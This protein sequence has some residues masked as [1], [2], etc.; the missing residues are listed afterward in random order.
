MLLRHAV[1]VEPPGGGEVFSPCGAPLPRGRVNK[2]MPP[3]SASIALPPLAPPVMAREVGTLPQ[4]ED[5]I[6]EFLWGGE[7]VRGVKQ[8]DSVHLLSRDGRDLTNRF[9]RIAAAIAKLRAS[10]AIIDGEIVH[11][12]MYPPAATRVLIQASDDLAQGTAALLAYDL[13]CD[14]GNDI[15]RFSLLCR[16]LLLAS[17]VQATPIALSPVIDLPADRV[18]SVAAEHGFHGVVAKRAGAPYRPNSS[19][20]DWVKV[21]FASGR[22]ARSARRKREEALSWS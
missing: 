17:A 6:Y 21:T 20:P 22:P 11:L 3:V 14:E 18:L 13:L 19:T 8:E 16:R 9:P 1:R 12:T 10:V 5:W 15:R 4:G 7:R 2:S